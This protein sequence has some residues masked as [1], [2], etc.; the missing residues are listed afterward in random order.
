MQSRNLRQFDSLNRP[1]IEVLR[2]QIKN[3]NKPL[4][5]GGGYYYGPNRK[6][7]LKD[8][9]KHSPYRSTSSKRKRNQAAEKRLLGHYDDHRKICSTIH[10]GE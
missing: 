8:G 5:T 6:L 3:V 7:D 2:S 4:R 9:K 10:H 1:P